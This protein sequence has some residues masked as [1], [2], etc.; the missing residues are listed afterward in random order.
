MKNVITC[1]SILLLIAGLN[2]SLIAQPQYYNYNTAG[3]GSNSF[4]FNIPAGKDVQLLYLPGDFNQPAPAPAGSITSISFF[5]SPSYSLGPWT[6]TDMTIKMG[7]S[8]ITSFTSGSFYPGALTTVYYR[9]SVS[10]SASAGTW[11]TLTLDSPFAYDPTQSLIVDVGQCGVPGA[12][13]YSAAFTTLTGNRR[14]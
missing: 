14:S 2:S 10:L 4:P 7:Q 8:G 9:A 3:S 6:Y 5:I 13:G 1:I 12:T 11:L